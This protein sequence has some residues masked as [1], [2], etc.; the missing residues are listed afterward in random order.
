MGAE[1][2]LLQGLFLKRRMVSLSRLPSPH[3]TNPKLSRQEKVE[4]G[5]GKGRFKDAH[6]S[7]P[8]L[9]AP[10]GSAPLI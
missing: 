6:Y 1:S 7:P 2:E 5:R 4:E 9:S 8:Q 3:L 10:E